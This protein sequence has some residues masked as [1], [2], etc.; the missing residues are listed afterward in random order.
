MTNVNT[1]LGGW[2]LTFGAVISSVAAFPAIADK[3]DTHRETAV[4]Q[5]R[6]SAFVAATDYSIYENRH[7]ETLAAKFQNRDW[8]EAPRVDV[9]LYDL[10]PSHD[11]KTAAAEMQGVKCLAEAIYY[12]SRSE[13]Y[14]G[15]KAV[16]EV[17][18]NR[19]K[20]KHYP[21]S[22]CGVVYEGSERKTGCQ[23]SF[24]CDGSTDKTPSG[25]H[26]ETAKDVAAISMT[27]G[28]T[29]FMGRATHYHTLDI[30]PHWADNLHTIGEVGDH[31]FYRFRWRERTANPVLAVAPPI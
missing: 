15:Q 6:A 5:A 31:K 9:A 7:A 19:V 27:G 24:T 13:S 4:W 16:A 20:S 14:A 23:F 12:E 25:Q 22:I 21:N 10:A 11:I 3:A 29:P 30:N 8:S 2:A 17:I 18:Q 26:W 28:Y 1:I